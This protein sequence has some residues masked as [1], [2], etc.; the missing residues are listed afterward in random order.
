M[1]LLE[2][3]EVMKLIQWTTPVRT[4]GCRAPS[5][6]YISFEYPD[7]IGLGDLQRSNNCTIRVTGQSRVV[8]IHSDLAWTIVSRPVLD[9]QSCPVVRGV[10]ALTGADE[11]VTL[12]RIEAYGES[13]MTFRFSDTTGQVIRIS[14]N[15]WAEVDD[16]LNVLSLIFWGEDE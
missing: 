4:M 7:L 11:L 6:S 14:N 13:P 2:S 10:P 12:L 3:N 9:L 16:E 8:V 1:R 5:D 15:V